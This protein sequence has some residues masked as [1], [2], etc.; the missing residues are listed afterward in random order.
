MRTDPHTSYTSAIF[1]I[2]AA[3]MAFQ[4]TLT[5]VF[6]IAQ[7]HHFAYMIISMA[8]LGFG[9]SGTLITLGHRLVSGIEEVLLRWSAIALTASFPAAYC[10]SQWIGFETFQLLSQPIQWVHLSLLYL[11]LSLPFFLTSTCIALAFLLRRTD[12]GALYGSNM[13]GS[14]VGAA[15]VVLAM[16]VVHVAQLPFFLSLPA[17]IGALFL[18][19]RTQTRVIISAICLVA[20]SLGW[21]HAVPIRVSQYK[22]LSN[23]LRFPDARLLFRRCGPQAEIAGVAS[24]MIRETP[25]EI[26]A[27]PMAR[28]GPLPEQIALFFDAGS[29]SVVNR[30]TAQLDHLAFL[31]YV[32]SAAPYHVLDQPDVLVLGAGGG[33]EVLNGLVHGARHVTAVD[34]NP[35]VF[36]LLD[37][38]LASFSGNIYQRPDVSP[39]VAEGRGFLR[40]LPHRF[41]LI[42]IPPMDSFVAAGAGVHALSE[43][44]LYTVEAV[45]L[46]LDRLSPGGMCAMSRWLKEPPRDAIKL[47]ATAVAALKRQ[48][49]K[50][51]GDHLAMIRSWNTGTLILSKS[52]L[53]DGQIR[54]L[55]E[56]SQTRNFDL[57]WLPGLTAQETNRFTVLSGTTTFEAAQAMLS[58]QADTFF[59]DA[60]FFVTPAVDDC[61]YFSRFFKWKSLASILSGMGTAWIP[62]IEWGYLTLLITLVQTVLVSLVFIIAPILLPGPRR[63]TAGRRSA[64]VLYFGGLGLGFMF[65]EIALMQKITQL[66]THPVYVV[67]VVLS[68]LLVFSGAGS[69]FAHRLRIQTARI[70]A[71][72]LVG[73]ILVA[74]LELMLL[75]WIIVRCAPFSD[76]VRIATGVLLMAPVGFIMGI[77]FPT[78]LQLLATTRPNMLAWAWAINGFTSV[79][80]ASLAV[81]LAIHLGFRNVVLIALLIYA[82]TLLP[83]HSLTRSAED[84]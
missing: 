43:H 11:I 74:L 12:I 18:C 30:T 67:A 60:P 63:A 68:G 27:Y 56:F 36:A 26:A 10:L 48:G 79:L 23:V 52:P 22:G 72:V 49:V 16:N 69:R 41:D 37:D 3:G 21:V 50:H 83:F 54:A 82:S 46:Y 65:L 53:S 45:A 75:P 59:E 34:T 17:G 31:D 20:A 77:P 64:V 62:L 19:H 29:M 55:R 33:T 44:Y 14:G 84:S 78:G 9:M 51:P 57:A 24:A 39:R 73:L 42:H 1:L 38:E 2:S 80:G 61:P 4:I 35:D 70:L 40:S 32:T 81:L 7:W 76:V 66:V 13:L 28:L 5:R 6:S 8:M 47:F 58:D 71:V 25:G 15:V